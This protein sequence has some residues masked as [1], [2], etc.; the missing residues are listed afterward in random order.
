MTTI[1]NVGDE[2]KMTLRGRIIEYT[3]SLNGDCYVVELRA[4]DTNGHKND[5]LRVY[6]DTES[7]LLGNAERVV[8][9]E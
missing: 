8:N 4:R 6:L 1:F 5:W 2:I 7:L 3:A 9:E